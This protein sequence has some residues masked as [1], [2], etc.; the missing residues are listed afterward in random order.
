MIRFLPNDRAS[1]ESC[2]QLWETGGKLYVQSYDQQER[3]LAMTAR[4]EEVGI[5]PSR[6]EQE[7]AG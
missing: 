2:N 7:P 5:Q 4:D 3:S 1:A 6:D